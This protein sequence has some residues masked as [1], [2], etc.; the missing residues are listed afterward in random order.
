MCLVKV[1]LLNPTCMLHVYLILLYHQL[2][3]LAGCQGPS[4][5]STQP[6]G[7]VGDGC[8]SNCCESRPGR[9]CQ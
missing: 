7:V 4:Y 9:R 2:S 8:I 1:C 3:S 6:S 5:G